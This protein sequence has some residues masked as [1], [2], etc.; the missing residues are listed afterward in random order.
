[1]FMMGQS[2]LGT[3][4]FNVDASELQECLTLMQISVFMELTPLLRHIATLRF[5]PF[6]LET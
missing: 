4:G 2:L 5:K 6:F 1:M 3:A